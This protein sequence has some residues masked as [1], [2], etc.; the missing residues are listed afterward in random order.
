MHT[1]IKDIRASGKKKW[2]LLL[3]FIFI[4]VLVVTILISTHTMEELLLREKF[5][6]VHN[7]VDAIAASVNVESDVP[8]ED[9][10]AHS[11]ASVAHI[12]E[13][14]FVYAAA[15]TQVDGELVLLSER[16][17]ATDFNPLDYEAFMQA[18]SDNPVGELT[19]GFTP[20]GMDYRDLLMYY[21]WMPTELPYLITI[22]VSKYSVTTHVPMVMNMSLWLMMFIT[23][24]VTMWSI[25]IALRQSVRVD[26]IMSAFTAFVK[27]KEGK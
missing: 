4:A 20:E 9:L 26:K 5:V 11:L 14:P 25:Y 17:N 27:K 3:P 19:I 6:A 22:G 8:V 7:I 13:L 12:D 21:K 10:L 1:I 15:F 2:L 23:F 24:I 16:D 18:T